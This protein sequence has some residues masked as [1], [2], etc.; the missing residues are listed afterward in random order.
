MLL[1]RYG[2]KIQS[3]EPNFDPNALTEIGFT[4]T[5]DL[6]TTADD[7]EEEYEKV[8]SHEITGR[9]EGGVKTE[10]EGELCRHLERSLMETVESLEPGE[11]LLVENKAGEDHP[12]MRD[13]TTGVVVAGENRFH[14][15]Y[16]VDPPI[17]V[18]VYRRRSG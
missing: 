13:K 16:T 8:S 18:G 15:E 7:F 9:T 11:V 5:S 14:F 3:V 12:K 2:S 17:R 10:V 1:R 6:S 4:R